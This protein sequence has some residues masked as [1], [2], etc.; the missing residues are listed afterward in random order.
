[1]ERYE[2]YFDVE[3]KLD[4]IIKLLPECP[5]T[6]DTSKWT[7]EEKLAVHRLSKL[8]FA[9]NLDGPGEDAKRE[10]LISY[11]VHKAQSRLLSDSTDNPSSI[12]SEEIDRITSFINTLRNIY[13]ITR[14]LGKAPKSADRSQW[15]SKE[16]VTVRLLTDW[17]W[18]MIY[19]TGKAGYAEWELLSPY[20]LNNDGNF[21][22]RFRPLPEST[23]ATE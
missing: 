4:N 11:F 23:V 6:N 5:T 18:H 14:L 20:F 2:D 15:N 3:P 10:L 16:K 7:P 19:G 21:T 12:E 1:M 17:Y 22:A 13:R 8:Y 9:T